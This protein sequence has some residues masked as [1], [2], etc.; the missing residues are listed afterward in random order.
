MDGAGRIDFLHCVPCHD[1]IVAVTGLISEGPHEDGSVVTVVEGIVGVPFNDWGFPLGEA[2]KT[3]LLVTHSVSF[4]IRLGDYV[5]AVFVAQVIPGM[6]VRIVGGPDCVD[7][8][9][10][11]QKNVIQH[12]LHGDCPSVQGGMLMTVDAFEL[13]YLAIDVEGVVNDFDLLES[14]LR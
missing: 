1:E 8:V 14:D 11:H 10:L 2:S 9:F 12:F 3:L 13:D 6:V 4:Y 5:D 7:I